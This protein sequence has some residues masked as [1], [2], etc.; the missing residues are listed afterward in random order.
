MLCLQIYFS[1]VIRSWL[2][3]CEVLKG[4]PK[5]MAISGVLMILDTPTGVG[6]EAML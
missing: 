5:A 3:Y 2:P 1:Q 6:G 4:P